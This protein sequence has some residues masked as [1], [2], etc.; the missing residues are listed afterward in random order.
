M[1]IHL[2]KLDSQFVCLK[3]IASQSKRDQ[4]EKLV[5][6]WRSG[7]GWRQRHRSLFLVTKLL[8]D[9]DT[10]DWEEP[11]RLV[12]IHPRLLPA[13]LPVFPPFPGHWATV[14]QRKPGLS[15]LQAWSLWVST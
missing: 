11:F 9:L 7:E 15:Q 3:G 2:E 13:W 6:L 8:E 5:V 1:Y 4:I 14:A 10:S 12:H